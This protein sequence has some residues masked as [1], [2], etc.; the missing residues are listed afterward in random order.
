MNFLYSMKGKRVENAH[1]KFCNILSIFLFMVEFAMH[2][3]YW[4]ESNV[5]NKTRMGHLSSC[6]LLELFES[7]FFELIQ[8]FWGGKQLHWLANKIQTNW[9]VNYTIPLNYKKFHKTEFNLEFDQTIPI[10][11]IMQSIF[12]KQFLFS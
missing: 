9:V 4:N 3:V 1:L 2:S 12:W 8:P 5:C 7:A 10:G 6:L 11:F